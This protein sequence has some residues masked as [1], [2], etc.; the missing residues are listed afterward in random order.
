MNVPRNRYHKIPRAPSGTFDTMNPD[1]GTAAENELFAQATEKLD[2]Y[3]RLCIGGDRR[4]EAK[5]F[6]SD[7]VY[8][9]SALKEF[10]EQAFLK[11]LRTYSNSPEID[12]ERIY[13]KLSA[14][15]SGKAEV[16]RVTG[17]F[18]QIRIAADPDVS[19]VLSLYCLPGHIEVTV[20]GPDD[21]SEW[22]Y[23]VAE[24]LSD[25][26][27]LGLL[28]QNIDDPFALTEEHLD[29]FCDII[30]YLPEALKRI[31]KTAEDRAAEL[32]VKYDLL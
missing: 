27:T 22:K 7:G 6:L 26:F 4:D 8:A 23:P 16:V 3:I 28:D 11:Y 29:E 15:L 21:D 12:M 10:T 2:L 18:D 31:R 32:S 5:K 1:A 9:R 24:Y 30:L 14:R 19:I 17:C 13:G 20:E 25:D